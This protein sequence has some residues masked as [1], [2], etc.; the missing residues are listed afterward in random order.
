MKVTCPCCN[1]DY[2]RNILK[3]CG[4]CYGIM[5]RPCMI[6]HSHGMKMVAFTP[7]TLVLKNAK[8]LI[9][10]NKDEIAHRVREYS[11]RGIHQ[12]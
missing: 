7:L 2:K 5:C 11:E 3:V 9:K 8:K 12:H 10:E 1:T 4:T 6:Q